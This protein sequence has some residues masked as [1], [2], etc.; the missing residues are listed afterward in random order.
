MRPALLCLPLTLAACANTM[1]GEVDGRSVGSAHDAIFELETIDLGPL[2]SYNT[3]WLIITGASDACEGLDELWDADGD[4]EEY[5]EELEPIARDHLP[6]S[7]VWTLSI[8]IAGTE[9][10]E[11]LYSHGGWAD[12]DGFGASIERWEVEALRDPAICEEMCEDGET[13]P[14]D[15]E[16]ST[17]GSIEIQTYESKESLEGEYTIEFDDDVVEG[18]FSANWCD[19]FDL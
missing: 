18:H 6:H 17:D 15:S 19:I 1:N 14:S 3:L 4:C 9:E 8:W 10:I 12:L 7:E 11:G 5:C 2:G 16:N 13:I